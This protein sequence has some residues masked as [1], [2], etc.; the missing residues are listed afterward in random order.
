MIL[1]LCPRRLFILAN[2]VDSHDGERPHSVAFHQGLRCIPKYQFM[3]FR[4]HR[5]ND[6]DQAPD[7]K[8]F[9]C[10]TQSAWLEIKGLW[11][12]ASQEALR[13]VFEH[14]TLVSA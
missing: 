2:S 1:Y 5:V 8:T 6:V 11:V 9:L 3:G 7:Y 12:P 4:I 14:D 10:S 13:C